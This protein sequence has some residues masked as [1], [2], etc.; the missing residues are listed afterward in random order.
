MTEAPDL[1]VER[2]V[3]AWRALLATCT[4]RDGNL[5]RLREAPRRERPASVWPLSQAIA[6]G[7]DLAATGQDVAD[8]L[9]GLIRSLR[10]YARRDGGWSPTPRAHRRY[11]DDNA[12]IG[13]ASARLYRVTGVRRHLDRAAR[14]LAFVERGEDPEGGVRWAEGRRSRNTCATAPGALLALRIHDRTDD[15]VAL[16]FA[17]RALDWLDAT[18]RRPDRLYADRID[19]ERVERT[20]WSYNQGSAAA[21]HVWRHRA[22]GD[23]G[24]RDIAKATA[25]ATVAWLARDD[26]LWH[27]PPVFNAIAFRGLLAVHDVTPIAGLLDLVDGYLHRA[28]REARDPESG[29]FTRRGIGSYDGRPAID[30]AGIA[31]LFAVRAAGAGAWFDLA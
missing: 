11:F 2:A 19:G 9:G 28:W 1:H 10:R 26:R 5:L 14:A 23:Q 16:D 29:L 30:Q 8:D 24:S 4:E 6:A 18:L 21:A 25:V 20:V 17:T 3:E 31:Q 12:W 22:T 27:Q 13:L 15:E 7:V